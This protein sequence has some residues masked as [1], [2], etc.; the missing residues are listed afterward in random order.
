M[1]QTMLF[2]VIIDL[3]LE[4][5]LVM[6]TLIWNDLCNWYMLIQCLF[7]LNYVYRIVNADTFL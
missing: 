5:L 4:G 1:L 6:N 2:I 3:D 7:I